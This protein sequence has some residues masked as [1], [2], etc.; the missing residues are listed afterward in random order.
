MVNSKIQKHTNAHRHTIT[1]KQS[2]RT[3]KT[4]EKNDVIKKTN[5][6]LPNLLAIISLQRERPHSK[7]NSELC[8]S[9]LKLGKSSSNSYISNYCIG[10]GRA[11]I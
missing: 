8:M 11:S 5:D 3:T 6:Y 10:F 9:V 2:V 1:A 7:L 4:V